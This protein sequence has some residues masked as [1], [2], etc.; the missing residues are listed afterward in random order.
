MKSNLPKDFDPVLYLELNDDVR[1]AGIDP[2]KHYEDFGVHEGRP[3]KPIAGIPSDLDSTLH[4]NPRTKRPKFATH[5]NIWEWNWS[6][7]EQKGFAR[8]G[9]WCKKRPVRLPLEKGHP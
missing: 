3:Y 9:D 5:E 8:V 7:R 4:T 2:T 6:K 1:T